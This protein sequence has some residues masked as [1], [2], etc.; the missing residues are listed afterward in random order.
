MKNDILNVSIIVRLHDYLTERWHQKISEIHKFK[1]IYQFIAEE[2]MANFSIWHLEDKA[3]ILDVEDSFI[4]KIKREI[5]V[6]NQRRNDL[7]EIIDEMLLNIILKNELI[8][9]SAPLH[10]ET[11]GMIID[12]LSILSLKLY[13]TKV[14]INRLDASHN[15]IERNRQRYKILDE[16]RK[17]LRDCLELLMQDINFKRKRF[18]L[19]KQM[20]MYNDV[21]LNPELYQRRKKNN[22]NL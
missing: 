18:K 22:Q 5:D 11:P 12:R 20:K 19:Y 1:G 3:R 14:E 16:Q 6:L 8:D 17:D 7:I 9:D 4:A 2:H 21:D 10:S 13:H 15:H